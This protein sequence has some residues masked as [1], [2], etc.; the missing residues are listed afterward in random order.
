ML[1]AQVDL[2]NVRRINPPEDGPEVPTTEEDA[3]LD[4]E[5]EAEATKMALKRKIAQAAQLDV[6]PKDLPP[7][8]KIHPDDSEDIVCS[9]LILPSK[10]VSQLHS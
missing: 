10:V 8:L 4:A 1:F 7:K 2:G 6:M 5:K 3:F 9:T